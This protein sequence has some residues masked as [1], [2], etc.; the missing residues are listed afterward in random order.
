MAVTV[1]NGRLG[2]A[3]VEIDGVDMGGSFGSIQFSATVEEA[4]I[5]FDQLGTGPADIVRTGMRATLTIPWAE[6]DLDKLASY[7][8]GLSVI[9]AGP[10]KINVTTGVGQQTLRDSLDVK[11]VVKPLL[12]PTT[13]VA[14]VDWITF[15]TAHLKADLEKS[16]TVDGQR[17]VNITAIALP[18]ANA[19]LYVLGDETA[20]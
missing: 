10:K 1:A 12:N 18:D 17:V 14:A 11:V 15:P 19:L 16:Y 13:P 9:G 7:M 2:P 3:I 20:A 4:E 8:P 5:K 6:A